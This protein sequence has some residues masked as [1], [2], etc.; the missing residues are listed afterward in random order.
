MK[1]VA[2]K[3]NLLLLTS[4]AF[5]A[6]FFVALPAEAAVLNSASA[7]TS[8]AKVYCVSGGQNFAVGTERTSIT[9]AS[10][11]QSVIS[12]GRFVCRVKDGRGVWER[13]GSLPRPGVTPVASTSPVKVFCIS[14]SE[15]FPVGTERTSITNASGTQSV[16]SDGRF[17]CRVKDGRGVWEREGSLPSKPTNPIC[18]KGKMNGI[19]TG[20]SGSRPMTQE[21]LGGNG[22]S[23]SIGGGT[24]T[25][26]P[27]VSPI[28]CRW[29]NKTYQEGMSRPSASYGTS[30]R[31]RITPITCQ[32][33]EWRPVKEVRQGNHSTSTTASTTK[34]RSGFGSVKGASTDIYQQMAAVIMVIQEEVNALEAAK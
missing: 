18:I 15:K 25:S 10:G 16:I 21:C 6:A 28:H 30:F 17:V 34:N 3:T 20:A 24:G 27:G 29:F 1:Q 12:D 22:S 26:K 5:F 14:G 7:A 31:S 9:N 32:N 19:S 23:T 13:E 4:V 8:P 33:G 2:L 11:T